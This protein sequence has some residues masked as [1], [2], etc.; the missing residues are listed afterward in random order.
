M[1]ITPS[2]IIHSSPARGRIIIIIII[3]TIFIVIITILL[4]E[5]RA[6]QTRDAVGAA[7]GGSQSPSGDRGCG[8]RPL[9][10]SS[11]APPSGQSGRGCGQSHFSEG[12]QVVRH[13]FSL[14]LSFFTLSLGGRGWLDIYGEEG[15]CGYCCCC[16]CV[17]VCA[18]VNEVGL[19]VPLALRY[20]VCICVEY[21]IQMLNQFDLSFHAFLLFVCFFI[22]SLYFFQ[23]TK[24]CRRVT[25]LDTES[26][27]RQGL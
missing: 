12:H 3:I 25:E 7:D 10:T 6:S 23:S 8:M 27:S 20:I 14:S 2:W 4:Q 26:S 11:S 9:P 15:K 5:P 18:L 21:R 24:F 22:I 19:C 13:F 1:T 16:C 17:S